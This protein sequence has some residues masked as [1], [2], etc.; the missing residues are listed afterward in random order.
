MKA[1]VHSNHS[2]PALPSPFALTLATALPKECQIATAHGATISI[3]DSPGGGA[4]VRI[5]F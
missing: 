2:M 1:Y 4:R 3:S 5:G